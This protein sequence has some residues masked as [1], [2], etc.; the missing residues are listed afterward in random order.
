MTDNSQ[1][2]RIF[3]VT[4]N[5]VARFTLEATEAE[6]V[7]RG[8]GARIVAVDPRDP[9]RVYVGT[10]DHGLYTSE[11][12]GATWLQERARTRGPARDVGRGVAV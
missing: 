5:D 12:G 7:L 9:D 11:D 2:T 3:A 4:G 6:V 8:V 10:F 1:T